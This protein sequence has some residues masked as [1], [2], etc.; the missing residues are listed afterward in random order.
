MTGN[1]VSVVDGVAL[2]LNRLVRFLEAN[3]DEVIVFAPGSSR[4]AL[5]P[6]GAF[7]PV[8]AALPVARPEYRLALGLSRRARKQL[9]AFRPQLVHLTTPDLL[10]RAGLRYAKRHNL[11]VVASFHTNFASYFKYML[12]LR[13]LDRVAWAYLRRFY[14]HCDHLYVPT[15]S[16]RDELEQQ[17]VETTMHLWERGVDRQRFNPRRRSLQ[18]RREHGIA[19]DE[20]VVLFVARLR[21]EKGLHVLSSVLKTLQSRKI[22]H[23]SVI[24]G[25]GPGYGRLRKSLPQAVMPGH[26]EGTMLAT[27]YASSDV[28]LFPSETET[29]GNVVLEAMASGLPTI[30]ADAPG[31]RSLVLHGETGWLANPRDENSFV[32]HTAWLLTAPTLRRSMAKQALERASSFTWDG[33]MRRLVAHYDELLDT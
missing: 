30:C 11:P 6:A 15:L 12:G 27:V 8:R 24:V 7:V 33:C 4:P 23:R 19:D 21:P 14:R 5:E 17:G 10:G 3:G 1:Y 2:T 16:M 26:L 28:F 22:P 20:V 18:W 29:I 9:D 32:E 25:D 13:Q 31:P